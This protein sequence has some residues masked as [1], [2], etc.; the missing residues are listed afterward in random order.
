M[1]NVFPRTTRSL[2]AST[3]RTTLWLWLISSIW[4]LMW[5]LWFFL[6]DISVYETSLIARFEVEDATHPVSSSVTGR[7]VKS[8]VELG[9]KVSKGD[10]L[11]Q[12]DSHT[13]ILQLAEEQAKKRSIPSQQEI[14]AS[15][16]RDLEK[17]IE[18]AEL[19]A[20]QAVTSAKTLHKELTIIANFEKDNTSR[21]KT[22]RS[23]G[24]SSEIELLRTKSTY[25]RAQTAANKQLRE[26]DRLATDESS[27]LYDKQVALLELKRELAVLDGQLELSEARSASLQEDIDKRTIRAPISGEIGSL[28]QLDVGAVVSTGD[29]I[30]N[31]I[32]S[33]ALNIVAEF[34]PER[35]LGRMF[36][37][38]TA[39]MKLD[40]FPWAQ[41]GIVQ[42]KVDQV[43]TEI[44]DGLI[45][46]EFALDNSVAHEMPLQHGLTGSVEV[47]VETTSPALLVLRASGQLISKP[48]NNN[49]SI[50][51]VTK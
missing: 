15:Q 24:Q 46:V 4:L 20:I 9:K 14:V 48:S 35:V 7:I 21:I 6:A 51:E 40:V 41:Y 2:Q 12:L 50:A 30:V 39:Y 19:S 28:P 29:L 11:V 17:A 31:L 1:A 45:R 37:G 36:R 26:I 8:D 49:I 42:L 22:L 13:Q 32:P 18:L 23:S 34:K 44:S 47:N 3:S 43:A 27:R 5:L 25:D 33:G 10:I 16:A 38:Q